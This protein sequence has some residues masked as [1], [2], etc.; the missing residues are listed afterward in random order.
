MMRL[1][2]V[3]NGKV[4]EGQVVCDNGI[5]DFVYYNPDGCYWSKSALTYMNMPLWVPEGYNLPDEK[6]GEA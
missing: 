4:F 5:L 1:K 2:N 6:G 3:A